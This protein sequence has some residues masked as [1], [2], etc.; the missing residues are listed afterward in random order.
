MISN[1]EETPKSEFKFSV[2]G[3]KEIPLPEPVEDIDFFIEDKF[4]CTVAFEIHVPSYEDEDEIDIKTRAYEAIKAGGDLECLGVMMK[5]KNGTVMQDPEGNTF[6]KEAW[7]KQK[8]DE[9]K[10]SRKE[11][12]LLEYIGL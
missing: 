3:T 8:T 9:L 1:P 10:I 11:K 2:K 6:D 5:D 7:V 12:P 4:D